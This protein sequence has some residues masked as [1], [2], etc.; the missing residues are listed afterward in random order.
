MSVATLPSE[1]APIAG[2]QGV[3]EVSFVALA[4]ETRLRHLY[5][6]DPLAI[7]FPT[8]PAGEP[9][10][11]VIVTTSGGLVGG[12]RHAVSVSVA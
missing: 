5:Q 11:A 8:P 4:G 12:D 9:P 6:T 2:V 1:P 3:A 7:M 10:T